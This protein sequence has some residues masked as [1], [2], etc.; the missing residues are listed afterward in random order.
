MTTEVMGANDAPHAGRVTVVASREISGDENS[1]S[2]TVRATAD[3]VQ[4]T[5]KSR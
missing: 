3:V 1:V 5:I 2:A 4:T